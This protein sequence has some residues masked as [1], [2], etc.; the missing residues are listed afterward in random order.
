MNSPRR[1]TGSRTIAGPQK[2]RV[3]FDA[4]LAKWLS[5][6][7][8]QKV[9]NHSP[10]GFEWGYGGSGPAQLALAILLDFGVA[11][12]RAIALY[13]RFKTDVIAKLP[14]EWILDASEIRKWL[15]GEK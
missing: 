5:P 11:R 9:L 8:S 2:V 3:H 12:P 13:Q 14:A 4:A 15:E 1:Y 6:K 10:Q 7:R